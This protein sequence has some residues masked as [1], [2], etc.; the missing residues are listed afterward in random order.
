MAVTTKYPVEQ[1]QG[2]TQL[3]LELATGYILSQLHLSHI[4]TTSFHT[5]HFKI[6][7]SFMK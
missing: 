5:I 4:L 3:M 2:L 7:L 1:P 6:I